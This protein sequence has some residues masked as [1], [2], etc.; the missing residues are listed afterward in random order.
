MRIEIDQSGKIEQTDL[1]TVIAFRNHEQYSILLKKRIKAEILNEYRNKY[2]DIH[3]R[4]FAILVFYCIRNYIHKIQLII[5]DIEYENKDAEIKNH[6][7]R[8]IYKEYMNFDK[9]LIIFSRIT[10]KSEAHRIAYQTFIGKLAPNKVM[11]K[12]EVEILL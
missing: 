3:Y 11:T 5:I 6:L 8:F 1:D 9:K 4:L 10:K 2:R 7:L 12:S